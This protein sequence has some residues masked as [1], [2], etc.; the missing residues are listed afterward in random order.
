MHSR[1]AASL[2]RR[3]PFVSDM[4]SPPSFYELLYYKSV[5]KSSGYESLS[6]PVSAHSAILTMKNQEIGRE[7][8][9]FG[10]NVA[11]NVP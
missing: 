6:F 2:L 9:V 4:I 8:P 1:A 11:E 5:S 3:E 10:R 7:I